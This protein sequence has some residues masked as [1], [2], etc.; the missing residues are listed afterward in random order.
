M[1]CWFG[2]QEPDAGETAMEVAE[3][4]TARAPAPLLPENAGLPE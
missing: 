3:P 4:L 1:L 2:L